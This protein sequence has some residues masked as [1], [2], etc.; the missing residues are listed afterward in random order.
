MI[1]VSDMST[2]L[3]GHIITSDGS[4]YLYICG[5]NSYLDCSS[6]TSSLGLFSLRRLYYGYPNGYA[7]ACAEE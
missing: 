6:Y 2:H 7:I 4:S 1:E 5:G 3:G